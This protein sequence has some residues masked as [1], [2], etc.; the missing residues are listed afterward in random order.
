[1][2]LTD[3]EGRVTTST[4]DKEN[5]RTSVEFAE[6]TT[7]TAYDEV[8]NVITVTRPAGTERRNEYDRLNRLT[9]VIDD[10]AGLALT[11]RFEYDA[12]GNVRHQYDSQGNHVEYTYDSL[13]RKTRH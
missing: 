12:K 8:G 10:P 3:E 5:R 13:D 2:T 4:Y 6:E 1:M 9:K 11:T 7:T